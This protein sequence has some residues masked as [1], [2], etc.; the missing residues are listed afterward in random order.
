MEQK[1][2]TLGSVVP[3]AMF[4][5]DK[6]VNDHWLPGGDLY[7]EIQ[8]FAPQGGYLQI[9]PSNISTG[10]SPIS[11][12]Q[13]LPPVKLQ[14]IS[15]WSIKWHLA[16]R[17]SCHSCVVF[18]DHSVY[19]VH[20]LRSSLAHGVYSVHKLCCKGDSNRRRLPTGMKVEIYT[21]ITCEESCGYFYQQFRKSWYFCNCRKS[22]IC[23]VTVVG[24]ELAR[25]LWSLK[26]LQTKMA[27]ARRTTT[28]PWLLL[29][30]TTR[31]AKYENKR[32]L[33]RCF[34]WCDSGENGWWKW[35]KALDDG[36][37]LGDGGDDGGHLQ[38]CLH[39]Q[40]AQDAEVAH[41]TTYSP[42]EIRHQLLSNQ[43]QSQKLILNTSIIRLKA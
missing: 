42:W 31:L 21:K 43:A 26:S 7:G 25:G 19:S 39:R 15:R 13:R 28:T 2:S 30:E 12:G 14:T 41:Q 36:C 17:P 8:N 6:I 23:L 16:G 10:W 5:K 24:A 9:L 20:K 33:Q 37:V 29:R 11:M 40:E 35:G 1:S 18:P 3:L 34:R 27:A 22:K 38:G 4:D 32:S